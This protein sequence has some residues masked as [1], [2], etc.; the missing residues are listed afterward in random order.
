MLITRRQKNNYSSVK[1]SM[2]FFRRVKIIWQ[3]SCP[4]IK[5]LYKDCASARLGKWLCVWEVML[6][7][8]LASV[9]YISLSIYWIISWNFKLNTI[10]FFLAY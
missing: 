3:K 4:T 9:H 2:L 1:T 10:F 5:Y 8:A 7:C 6:D